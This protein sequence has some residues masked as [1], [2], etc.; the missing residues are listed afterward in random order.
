MASSGY[1][2]KTRLWKLGRLPT[3]FSDSKGAT[4]NLFDSQVLGPCFPGTK[5]RA[6]RNK[7]RAAD[8]RGSRLSHSLEGLH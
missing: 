6:F 5:Q 1:K 8:G 3:P 7:A 4:R 2:G